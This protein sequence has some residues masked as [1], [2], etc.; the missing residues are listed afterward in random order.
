MKLN[1]ADPEVLLVG[2]STAHVLDCQS[3][4]VEVAL[5]Q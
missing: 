5:P 4:L 2:N 3:V 1:P